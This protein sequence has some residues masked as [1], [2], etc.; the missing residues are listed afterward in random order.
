MQV[1]LHILASFIERPKSVSKQVLRVIKL[2]H[3][4]NSVPVVAEAAFRT[5]RWFVASKKL[6]K[7]N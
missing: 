2:L 4:T 6:S 3:F 1:R 5:F 7:I